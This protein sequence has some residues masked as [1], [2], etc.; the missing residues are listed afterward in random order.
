MF[1][2]KSLAHKGLTFQ[3]SSLHINFITMLTEDLAPYGAKSS[4]DT[5]LTKKLDDCLKFFLSI[6]VFE[7]KSDNVFQNDLGDPGRWQHMNY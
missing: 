5:V 2:L 3:M 1:P 7:F 4:E 6:K